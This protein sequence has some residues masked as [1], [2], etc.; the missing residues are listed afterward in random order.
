MDADSTCAL[1]KRAASYPEVERILV[2][3]G[4]KKKLCDTVNRRPHMAAQDPAVLGPRLSFP[5]AHRLPAGLAQLQ[6]A[7]S[8][9]A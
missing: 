9:P 8:D 6:G 2:N 5:Y 7:G 4:I 1:L 3:P